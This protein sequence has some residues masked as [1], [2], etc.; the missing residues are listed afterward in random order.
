VDDFIPQNVSDD[1]LPEAARSVN[2]EQTLA[3]EAANQEK[4]EEVST[5]AF[6]SL[7][8]KLGFRKG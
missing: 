3:A 5:F 7:F 1:E 2:R 4:K 6:S 8:S